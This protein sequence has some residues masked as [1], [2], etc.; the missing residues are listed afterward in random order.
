MIK[1]SL[2]YTKYYYNLSENLKAGLNFLENNDLTSMQNGKYEIIGNDVYASIQE[3]TT[4]AET[5]CRWE[6]HRKYIDIQC[7]IK[8]SEKIGIGEIQ[9]FGAIE[10]YDET[11][12]VEF[13]K[14]NKKYQT[15]TLYS[16]DFVIFYPHDVHM[17]Q[18]A[19]N[20]PEYIKKVV[21]KVKI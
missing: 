8:G 15:T 6:A 1:N 3:Y 10:L 16:N 13:L 21:V 2:K 7:I 19:E 4:K 12:D 20:T 17:P 14:T 9:D 11:K 18:I 5:D